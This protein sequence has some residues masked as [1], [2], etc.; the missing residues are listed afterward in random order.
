MHL[1]DYLLYT[2]QLLLVT[3]LVV[4]QVRFHGERERVL[5]ELLWTFEDAG[6]SDMILCVFVETGGGWSPNISMIVHDSLL[7]APLHLIFS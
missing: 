7:L 5:R 1:P 3:R 4:S 6:V 2:I